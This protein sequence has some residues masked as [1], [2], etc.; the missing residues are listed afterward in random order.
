MKRLFRF[1]GC[2]AAACLVSTAA[3]ADDEDVI[4]IGEFQSL[5]GA[6]ASYGISSC[7]GSRLA[8]EEINAAGGVLGKKIKLITEDDRSLPGEPATIIRKLISR[9]GVVAVLGEFASSRA[10]EAAPIAQEMKIPML[11]PGA[12]N[13]KVTEVGD[14]I[15]RN[16]FIDP[17]QG[18]VMSKFALKQG[19][20]KVAVL[21]DEKQDYSKGLAE[22][23]KK[24]FT[25]NGGTIVKEQSYS[26]G[27]RDFK[28]QLTSIR[29]AKPEAIFLPGY[30]TEVSLI[31]RQARQLGLK[32]P[33]LGGDGWIGNSLLEVAKGALDGSYLSSHWSVENQDPAVQKFVAAYK[34]KYGTMPDDM[35]AL[36]YDG[37]RIV[38]DAIRRAGVAEPKAI[39]DALAQTKDFPGVTGMITIDEKRNAKKPAVIQKIEDG[40]FRFVETVVP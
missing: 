13:E 25:E 7:N 33:F 4:K 1:L 38:V 31:A 32:V 40:K 30:Y 19:F 3:L 29:A 35:A 21:V 16:C 26:S 36:G 11:S 37:L 18:T 34:A 28:A 10:L 24:H 27:D 23:F 22:S 20:K 8:M 6:N 17:F 5:T 9:D 2:A 15:F 12:T 14:Y 39:R